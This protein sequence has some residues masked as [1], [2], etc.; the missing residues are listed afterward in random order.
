[1]F[2]T[3]PF[4]MLCV[5]A[6]LCTQM[7]TAL[8]AELQC[9]SNKHYLGTKASTPQVQALAAASTFEPVLSKTGKSLVTVTK[10]G[11]D[12]VDSKS[13]ESSWLIQ[14]LLHFARTAKEPILDVGAG[15]GRLSHLLLQQSATVVFNELDDRQLFYGLNQIDPSLHDR[16]YLNTHR[17]PKN[18]IIPPKKLSAVVFHRVLHFMRADEIEEGLAKVNK[19]LVPGGKVYIAVLPPQHGEY[20][21]KVL[22]TYDKNWANGFSWP[23]DNLNS[24]LLLPEQVYALPAKLHVMDERPLKLALEKYGFKVEKSGFIDMNRFGKK[25]QRQGKEL[26][27]IIAVKAH[28]HPK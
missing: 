23:G 20:Q 17:F 26:F 6:A 21:D 3:K 7:A 24:K 9:L 12:T 2:K 27:G 16:L 18:M 28:D 8:S 19:W 4:L 10:F 22:A 14:D 15:Y 1:M 5:I 13:I 25:E 11:F